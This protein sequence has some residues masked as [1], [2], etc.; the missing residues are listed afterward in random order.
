MTL[1][2]SVCGS[3]GERRRHEAGSELAATLIEL[4]DL[5]LLGKQ[6]Q[7][8]VKG[9]L[10]PT[11]RQSLDELVEAWRRMADRAAERATATGYW[12]DGQADAVANGAEH[13]AVPQGPIEDQ[14]VLSLLTQ[15][16]SGLVERIE[17][18]LARIGTLDPISY[19][20]LASIIGELAQQL[21]TLR[22][23]LPNADQLANT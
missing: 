13:T 16:L 4:V 5:A 21:R 1:D 12:P 14:A 20:V 22:A 23:Q 6:L 18:R 11:L 15:C 7:W 3:P 9:P 10:F 2:D 8:C 17:K 19:L